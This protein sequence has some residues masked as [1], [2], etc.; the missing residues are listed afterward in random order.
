MVEMDFNLS[1]NP[2]QIKLPVDAMKKFSKEDREGMLKYAKQVTIIKEYYPIAT[3]FVMS[4][5]ENQGHANKGIT[6]LEDFIPRF[7]DF[8]LKRKLEHERE[9]DDLEKMFSLAVLDQYENEE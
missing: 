5:L 6:G 3:A 7:V 1:K 4:V 8:E 2:R 9:M